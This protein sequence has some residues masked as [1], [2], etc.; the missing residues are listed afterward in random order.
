MDL[1]E[2]NKEI[3]KV[4][5]SRNNSGILEFEGYS[6]IEMHQIIHFLFE[7]N[8][9]VKIKQLNQNDFPKIPIFNGVKFLAKILSKQEGIKLTARGFL[10]T[11]IVTD[12]YNQQ[13]FH[14][15]MIEKGISK[16]Y[17]EADSL[18]V[19]LSRIL[20][21]LCGGVK[22]SK[23]KLV[24]TK[25]GN[26]Y[27]ENDQLFLEEILIVYCK[28]LNWTYFDGYEMENIGRMGCGYSILLLN[29]YGS[30]V[31]EDNFY[32]KK[33]FTA[34]PM[35]IEDINP[36]YGT[37]E[38]YVNRCYSYRMV[39][40]FGLLTGIINKIRETKYGEPKLIQKTDLLDKIFEC[41]RPGIETKL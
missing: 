37:I 34:F 36:R 40:Q 11:K 32:A 30:E 27:L 7:D 25:K 29:K 5:D 12:L 20:L 38:Q 17:K 14:E 15:E 1:G 13:Y 8:C 9:P 39:E 35:L 41:S 26:K 28:K 21:E 3:K 6:P 19:R 10:P 31:Q 23:G 24:L 4:M 33:Y 16:L 18:F 2:I 22:K